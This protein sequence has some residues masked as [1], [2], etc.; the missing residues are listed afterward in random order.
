MPQKKRPIHRQMSDR[1]ASSNALDNATQ[2]PVESN[3]VGDHD[4]GAHTANSPQLRE[5]AQPLASTALEPEF[6]ADPSLWAVMRP[7]MTLDHH[8]DKNG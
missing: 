7:L 1:K 6:I 3:E 5:T 4:V 2:S 8:T